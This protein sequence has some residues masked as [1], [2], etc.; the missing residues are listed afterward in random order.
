[1]GNP[2]QV[3]SLFIQIFVTYDFGGFYSTFVF[4]EVL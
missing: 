3:F 2:M 4:P 1:M